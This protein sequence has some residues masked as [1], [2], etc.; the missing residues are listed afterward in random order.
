MAGNKPKLAGSRLGPILYRDN[1]EIADALGVNHNDIKVLV[2]KHGLPAFKIGG[3][4]KWKLR[5]ADLD[6]WL[7]DQQEKY[8]G[9]NYDG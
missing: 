6:A 4:G 1:A 2:D 3:R 9:V 8:Q 7:I 5:Q